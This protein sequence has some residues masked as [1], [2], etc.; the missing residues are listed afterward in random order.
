MKMAMFKVLF[1]FRQCL[2]W[3]ILPFTCQK[4]QAIDN[5]IDSKAIFDFSKPQSSSYHEIKAIT[6][7]VK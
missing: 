5:L 1:E 2:I 7:Y 3:G 6:R 4:Q